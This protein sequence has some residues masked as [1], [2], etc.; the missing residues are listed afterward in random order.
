MH[1][2]IGRQIGD[3][4]LEARFLGFG[5]PKQVMVGLRH[6]TFPSATG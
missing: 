1:I 5:A 2:G 6:G 4:A 3:L